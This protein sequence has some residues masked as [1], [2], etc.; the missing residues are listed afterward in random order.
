MTAPRTADRLTD[1]ELR[2]AGFADP[3]RARRLLIGLAGSGVTDDDV[4]ELLPTLLQALSDCPDPDRS[5]ANFARWSEALGNRATHFRY[6]RSH[7]AGVRILIQ[8][9][10][11]SQFL[12]DI[13]VRNP[14]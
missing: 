10:A 12:A 14:E 9:G 2:A 5:L 8:I 4:A 7:P 11:T 6:L 3:V 13:L 1:E